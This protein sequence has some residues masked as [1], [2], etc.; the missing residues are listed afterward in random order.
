MNPTRT[1]KIARLPRTIREELNLRL[2]NGEVGKSLVAWLNEQDDVQA[3]LAK[4]FAGNPVTE[5]NLSEWRQGGFQDWLREQSTRTWI[6]SLADRT[7]NIRDDVGQIPVSDWLSAPLAV[8]LG[9]TLEHLD[10]APTGDPEFRQEL[11]ALI[12]GLAQLRRSDHE[13]QR[14]HLQ[15]QRYS[16]MYDADDP[17]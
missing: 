4:Y 2:D 12:R 14:L 11:L 5:Q 7:K 8:I 1:G 16:S 10:V 9:R 13:Q 6:R 15:N 3:V 17:D